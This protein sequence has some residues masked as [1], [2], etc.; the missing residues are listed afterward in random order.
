MPTT[1]SATGTV[2]AVFGHRL[3]LDCATTKILADLGP[4]ATTGAL[5]TVGDIVTVDGERKPC[6]IK[7]SRLILADGTVRTIVRPDQG[8]GPAD[9]DAA[10]RLVRDAGY[11]VEGLPIRK[12]KHFQIRGIRDGAAFEVHV[13]DDGC[14][15]R[16]KR[17]TA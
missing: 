3:A 16:E 15:R 17:L 13:H 7:V 14:I 11:R 4:K 12:P 5:P 10:L 9:T 6:E 2:W 8:H 1:V